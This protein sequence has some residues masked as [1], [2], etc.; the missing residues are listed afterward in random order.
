MKEFKEAFYSFFPLRIHPICIILSV[1]IFIISI[2]FL[3]K[4]I[5]FKKKV[6]SYS[7]FFSYI[8]FVFFFTVIGR[9]ASSGYQ[10]NLELFWSYKRAFSEGSLVNLFG[11]SLNILLFIPFGI[12]AFGIMDCSMEK[13]VFV[14]CIG[15]VLSLIIELLQLALKR[16]LFEFDDIFHNVIGM[17][18]GYYFCCAV[19]RIK[20]NRRKINDIET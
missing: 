7:I 12:C 3:E 5:H 2:Y 4:K 6:V 19:A 8:L 11:N 18:L 14:G 1:L 9:E 10:Y 17:M 16:G 20:R 13:F 15:M